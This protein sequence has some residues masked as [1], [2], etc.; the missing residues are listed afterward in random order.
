MQSVLFISLGFYNYDDK[1]K[2]EIENLGYE[3]T[4]FTPIG[5]YTAIEKLFNAMVKGR[6]LE[7]KTR[8]RQINKLLKEDKKYDYVFVIV[9]RHLN[10]DILK[11]FKKNQPQAKFILYLWDDVARVEHFEENKKYYEKIYSFDLNDVEKYGFEHLPLFYTSAHVYNGE[12]KKYLL[13]MS[14][15]IHSARISV[16]DKIMTRYNLD[17][18][19]SFIYMLGYQIKHYIQAVLPVKNKWMSPKYIHISGMKFETMAEIM[20]RSKIALDVQFGSQAGLTMRT[21][22]SLGCHT[23]LITTNPYVKEYDFYKY[24]NIC[25]ID[26]DDPVVPEDFFTTKYN[27]VPNEIVSKY[28]LSNWVYTILGNSK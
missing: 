14:G 12:K 24:G 13:N 9:G 10:P 25:I 21:I 5:K 15:L 8:R 18:K 17:E 3:V 26:K 4:L 20:K 16:L 1:I 23:K 7:R 28:A 22:E 19:K 2:E 27:D 11:R 6:Y